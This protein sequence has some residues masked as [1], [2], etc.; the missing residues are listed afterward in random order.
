[1]KIQLLVAALLGALIAVLWP[2]T[3]SA[4]DPGYPVRDYTPEGYLR[5]PS[6]VSDGGTLN[7]NEHAVVFYLNADLLPPAAMVGYRYG[8]YYWWEIGADVG[9]SFGVFQ[10]LLHTKFEN[11]RTLRSETFYWGMRFNTGFKHHKADFGEQALFDDHS[12]IYE[13]TNTF[14]LRFGKGKRKNFYLNTSFYVDQDLH[15]PRRQTDYYLRAAA[16]GFETVVSKFGNFFVD[17]GMILS[18]NGMETTRG[19]L[20][21]GDWFPVMRI[22]FGARTDDRTAIYYVRATRDQ[23]S[24]WR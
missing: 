11:F 4:D 13:I 1:V 15:D 2:P 19:V 6:F 10:A 14:S 18:I 20:Y 23:A 9:S 12:W 8:L 3:A 21:E 17:A 22:G 24:V 7:K 16:L 5:Q